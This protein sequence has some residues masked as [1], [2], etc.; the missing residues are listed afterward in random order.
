MNLF[1]PSL[2]YGLFMCTWNENILALWIVISG[3]IYNFQLFVMFLKIPRIVWQIW[4]DV[5]LHD[6]LMNFMI[7]YVFVFR[8][9]HDIAKSNY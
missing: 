6:H 9:V 2:V 5:R 3:W 7:L 4:R 8:R 1:I